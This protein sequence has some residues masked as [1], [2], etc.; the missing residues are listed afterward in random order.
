MPPSHKNNSKVYLSR[1]GDL[2]EIPAYTAAE[3]ARHLK[4]PLPTLRSW[5]KGR[6]YP[7]G[8]NGEQRFFEPAILLSYP[9]SSQLSIIHLIEAHVQDAMRR[10]QIVPLFSVRRALETL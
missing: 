6:Y 5:I 2:R 1:G 4:I 8:K 7:V 9:T 3:A 10:Q